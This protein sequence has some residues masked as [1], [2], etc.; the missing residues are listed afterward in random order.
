MFLPSSFCTPD[1]QL[2]SALAVY[3]DHTSPFVP[4][5]YAGSLTRDHIIMSVKKSSP[6]KTT[7]PALSLA[8]PH[9]K[10]HKIERALEI[11]YKDVTRAIGRLRRSRGERSTANLKEPEGRDGDTSDSGG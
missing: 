1:V 7:R 2:T 4:T 3:I 8:K 10:L 9:G 5:S 6:E 11:P